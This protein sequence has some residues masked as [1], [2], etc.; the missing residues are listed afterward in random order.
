M[1][2]GRRTSRGRTRWIVRFAFAVMVATAL[3]TGLS[4][5]RPSSWSGGPVGLGLG[6]GMCG[7][8]VGS[9]DLSGVW[10][11]A[12]YP[13][14]TFAGGN[15]RTSM[16]ATSGWYPTSNSASISIGGTTAST[17][18]AVWIPLWWLLA[19]SGA[20]WWV[21]LRASRRAGPG[22]CPA[23]LYNLAGLAAGACPECGRAAPASPH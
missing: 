23:C 15:V 14:W 16:W 21:A 9:D 8:F 7:V 22:E 11:T 2:P 5:W 18:R 19:L 3:V 6:R 12:G 20:A 10:T 17:L 1:N 4:Y 13:T